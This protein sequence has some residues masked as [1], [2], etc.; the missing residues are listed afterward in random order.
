MNG[1]FRYKAAKTIC[2]KL[3][4]EI[5]MNT[6]YTSI[7]YNMGDLAQNCDPSQTKKCEIKKYWLPIIQGDPID[8]Q[9]NKYSWLDDRPRYK[10]NTISTTKW[11]T[12]Q[13]NGMNVT[14]CVESCST[15]AGNYLWNDQV[16]NENN[17]F[18]C[19]LPKHQTFYLRGAIDNENFDREYTLSLDLQSRPNYVEFVGQEK[20]YLHWFIM[21]DRAELRNPSDDLAIYIHQNPFGL[22]KA[23]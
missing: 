14:Q 8:G 19:D 10:G 22:I 3:G 23:E 9:D 17:F 11:G 4:G 15:G 5:S 18:I 21:E 13:P 2:S 7:N 1:L 16:C 12:S 20:S 6:N